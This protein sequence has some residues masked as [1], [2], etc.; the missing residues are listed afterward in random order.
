MPKFLTTLLIIAN[1]LVAFAEKDTKIKE[2]WS[3][4]DEYLFDENYERAIPYLKKLDNL[5][6]NEAK[7]KFLLAKC[8]YHSKN[9]ISEDGLNYALKYIQ[10]AGPENADPDAYFYAAHFYQLQYKFDD[11]KNT[12]QTFLD[13]AKRG[14][15]YVN[16]AEKEIKACSVAKTKVDNPINYNIYNIGTVI[17][18]PYPDYVP[19]ISADE[20][21]I[22]F[23][24]RRP[25]SKGGLQN[26]RGEPDS[27]NGAYFEDIFIATKI[28]DSTWSQP[29]SIGDNINTNGHD[30]AI[31]LSPDGQQLFIYKS[32]GY[33]YGD[34]F[35]SQLD[36]DEWQTPEPLPYPINSKYWEG[37]ASI[38]ADG[39]TLYFSSNRPG[40]FGGRDI[41]M[42]KKLPDGN[43]ANPKNLGP[44]VNTPYDDDAPFIHPDGKTLYFSSRGHNSIGGY[45]I[46]ITVNKERY[47]WTEPVNMG[48]PV[49]TTGND[50]YFVLSASGKHGYYSS[51]NEGTLGGDDI[52][53]IDMPKEEWT[54]PEPLTVLKGKITSDI[55]ETLPED[56]KIEVYDNSTKELIGIFKPNMK[57][58][59]YLLI[60]PRGNDY[61]VAVLAEGHLFHSENIVVPADQQEYVEIKNNIVLQGVSEGKKIVLRNIFFDFDQST[62][63]E[64]SKTEL[65]R[66]FD[67]LFHDPNIIVEISGHTDSKGAYEYNL[68][69]SKNRAQVVVDYLIGKGIEEERMIANGYG[70]SEPIAINF[71]ID[72]TDNP[73]GRQLNR[74]TEMKIVSISGEYS[75]KDIK[76]IKKKLSEEYNLKML[77][78]ED[79][80][81]EMEGTTYKVF[82]EELDSNS[83]IAEEY[84]LGME[85]ISYELTPDNHILYT[86]GLFKDIN[87]AVL[88]AEKLR[89]MG[90]NKAKVIT[91]VNG[92]HQLEE[93][94]QGNP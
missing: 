90:I 34:I 91:Y 45:D 55:L 50:I 42:V 87:K 3:L 15:K 46:F 39:R 94:K 79:Y 51:I 77:S 72:G 83:N 48:Y 13:K 26:E 78:I 19:V 65:D 93:S 75:K 17:N 43:W 88:Y 64:S 35:I 30:A 37:S 71:F 82:V 69:L 44:Q 52:E 23:T 32:D 11:A 92:V 81:K 80:R 56:L 7:Y 67:L 16:E 21:I 22:I 84:F 36:G 25:G 33:K 70:E 86:A 68:N 89:S 1:I 47:E 14:N 9:I 29:V 73:E 59:N 18:S 20:S 4:A 38:S 54:A 61:N 24:S 8:Y 6:Q 2:L 76:K 63:R 57:T 74:R 40:G 58:G 27:I 10:A 53:V 66:M 41:Y 62:L 85:N 31:G 60:V 12:Y 49:N 5:D 28:N